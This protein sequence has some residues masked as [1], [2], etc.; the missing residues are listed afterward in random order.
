MVE[1]SILHPKSSTTIFLDQPPSCLQ[2]CPEDPSYFVVGTYFLSETKD[3]EGN[4]TAQKKTG[5][6][7]LWKLDPV[8][9][10]LTHVE[11][12]PL[13]YAVFDLHFHPRDPTLLGIASSAASVAFFRVSRT[14]GEQCDP[15]IQHI[16]TIDVHEDSSIPALFLAWS[17]EKFLPGKA[18]AFAVTYSDGRTSVFET[19]DDDLTEA[20]FTE[21]QFQPKQMIEVWFVALGT[22]QEDWDNDKFTS[23]LFTGDDFGTLR[24]IRFAA[25]EDEGK[26]EDDGASLP[27]TLLDYSDRA[28]HHTA[29]VTSI[30]PLSVPLFQ[31]APLILTGSYD[32]YLRVYHATQRGNVLAELCL[33]GG[34]WRLQILRSSTSSEKTFSALVLASCM[35]T[36]TRLLRVSCNRWDEG[37]WSIEVLAK[38]TEHESM[39][40]ASDVWQGE[41]LDESKPL[42]V[43]SSFYDRRVCVWG[44]DF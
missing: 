23:F 17:P 34:V 4:V 3:E 16:R 42:V 38:F 33:G 7:Q 29:G 41:N 28:R 15:R 27:P 32:E 14:T 1:E 5:S 24:T 12:V 39:N 8:S 10:N 11:T 44:A 21:H 19:K 36:G 40:Y 31:G 22:F 9:R 25:S 6:L 18:E 13:P 43:S 20:E 37:D 30:L 26:T 2:F 35:H